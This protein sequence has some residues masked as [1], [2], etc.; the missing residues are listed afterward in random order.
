LVW[1]MGADNLASF[2][3]WQRWPAIAETLPIAVFNRPGWALRALA[4]PAAA[5]LRR[6]RF[7]E[8]DAAGLASAWPPAWVF[9]PKPLIN[10]SSSSLRK[11]KPRATTPS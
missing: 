2:H 1:L 4:S 3:R 10:L 9:I 11:G 7:D 6:A 8:K 5:A